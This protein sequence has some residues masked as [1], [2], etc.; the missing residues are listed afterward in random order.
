MRSIFFVR[1][2]PYN[3]KVREFDLYD[4][5]N[6]TAK[7]NIDPE[8]FANSSIF[9]KKNL[10]E[11]I[12]KS[13]II[14]CPPEK[15]TTQTAALIDKTKVCILD[16]LKEISYIMENFISKADFYDLHRGP[17]V[18]AARQNFFNAFVV[19]R[20]LEN[21]TAVL[22]RLD[23]VLNRII[24]QESTNYST[25]IMHGFLLKVLEVYL[26]HPII[27]DNPS[28]LL[29][30]YSGKYIGYK[31]CEGFE[32]SYKDNSLEIIKY[33]RNKNDRI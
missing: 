4:S 3:Y 24:E 7:G 6:L 12:F 14:Y 20:V 13:D 31:F 22:K 23:N 25:V 8:I 2:A 19:G 1:C 32:A 18:D 30:Y 27:K 28:I 15:R 5:F 29:K 26:R 16:E 17:K 21:P 11:N 9:L 10:P 33:I